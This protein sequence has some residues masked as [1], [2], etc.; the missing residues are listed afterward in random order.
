ML[1]HKMFPSQYASGAD[2][3]GRSL[4]L[5]ISHITK[6]EVFDKEKQ[7][8]TQ[9]WVLYFSGAKKGVLLGKT[10][11][12]EIADALKEPDTDNWEGKAIEL[13]PTNVKAFGKIHTVIRFRKTQEAATTT[14]PET[15]QEVGEEDETEAHQPIDPNNPLGV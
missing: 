13:Y 2:L 8:K 5:T 15:M 11:A 4:V 10:Q 6:E 9:K 12:T 3:G 7:Q 14:A 1:I